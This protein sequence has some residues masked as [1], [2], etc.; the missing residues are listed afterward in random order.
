M[1]DGPISVGDEIEE[2]DDEW[3]HKECA[4]EA[5]ANAANED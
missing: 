4:D 2:C 1:C 3:C 5:N